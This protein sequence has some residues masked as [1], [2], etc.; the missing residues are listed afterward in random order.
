LSAAETAAGGAE[1]AL[2]AE[3]AIR[4]IERLK[5]FERQAQVMLKQIY[6][7]GHASP[8]ALTL[9][10]HIHGCGL[11]TACAIMAEIVTI[12]RFAA[13]EQLAKYAGIAPVFKSSGSHHRLRTNPFGNRLLNK[14]L[15]TIALSQIAIKGDDRGKQY[16]RKKLREGKTKLWALRCLKRQLVN[17]VFR[18]LKE[19]EKSAVNVKDGKN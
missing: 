9:Y 17:L 8:Q 3:S 4:R 19:A 14:A 7:V 13:R 16:Y 11:L 2:L 12:K 5:L 1:H 10:G 18:T 6:R 15:H